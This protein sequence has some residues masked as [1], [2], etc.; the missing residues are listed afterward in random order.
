MAGKEE[1]VIGVLIVNDDALFRTILAVALGRQPGIEVLGHCAGGTEVPA[2]ARRIQP[3]V[4]LMD[5]QMP[6]TGGLQATRDLLAAQPAARVI[7]LTASPVKHAVTEAAEAGA[8][9]Y[10]PKGGDLEQ[11]ASA[12][13]VV[14]SGGTT[15][16]AGSSPAVIKRPHP[17]SSQP[18]V[19]ED[20]QLQATPSPTGSPVPAADSP[21]PRGRWWICKLGGLAQL[22]LPRYGPAARWYDV[23]S[24]ERPI[25]RAGRV[26]GLGMLQ[27]RPGMRVLDIGCG[28][29]LNF[30]LLRAA[31]GDGGVVVGLDSSTAMLAVAARRIARGG[32]SN[33]QILRGDAAAWQ[34]VVGG[35]LFDAAV[36]TYSLSV[37][38]DWEL[39]WTA[40]VRQLRPGA[41]VVV[42]DLALPSGWGRLLSPLARLACFTGG[43]DPRRAPWTRVRRDATGVSEAV[44]RS[45]HIHIAAGTINPVHPG[46]A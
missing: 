39:A 25:Y 19:S 8:S 21:A 1:N 35:E 37:I 38:H 36:F 28:T 34:Q 10:L 29:G 22:R 17:H 33:V 40:A 7:I 24:M 3:D 5:L 6:G 15:W 20:W 16:P 23:L 31:A 44:L 4:V 12:I 13:R 46:N 32:W 2:A 26:R 18:L 11:V 41:R 42:V 14:A 9:G 43:S 27:V 30:P 45:G